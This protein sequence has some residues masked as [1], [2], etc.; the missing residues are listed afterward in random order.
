MDGHPFVHTLQSIPPVA[1]SIAKFDIFRVPSG[2]GIVRYNFWTSDLAEYSDPARAEATMALRITLTYATFIESVGC[3]S[4]LDARGG[5]AMESCFYS[6]WGSF[7]S[8]AV[9]AAIR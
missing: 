5:L 1:G 2:V 9:E 7:A 3:E 4:V 8:H 6:K